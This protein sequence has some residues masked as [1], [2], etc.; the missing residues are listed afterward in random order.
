MGKKVRGAPRGVVAH[1]RPGRRGWAGRGKPR[2]RKSQ[3]VSPVKEHGKPGG[4]GPVGLRGE[5]ALTFCGPKVTASGE[6]LAQS[7]PASLRS[8]AFSIS[9][10]FISFQVEDVRG[11]QK[12]AIILNSRNGPRPHPD[13]GGNNVRGEYVWLRRRGARA[14]RERVNRARRSDLTHPEPR[15]SAPCTGRLLLKGNCCFS[16][17]T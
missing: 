9:C 14:S 4:G 2:E 5:G 13:H 11:L 17:C 8:A 12:H 15:T 6:L 3:W 1:T 7:C 16:L 10:H